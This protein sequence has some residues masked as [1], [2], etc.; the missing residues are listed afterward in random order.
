MP[1]EIHHLCSRKKE[2]KERE[3]DRQKKRQQ[4]VYTSIATDRTDVAV[5]FFLVTQ[6]KCNQQTAETK[7]EVNY[8]QIQEKDEKNS[9]RKMREKE[10]KRKTRTT[11]LLS[12]GCQ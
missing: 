4:E 5:A 9:K 6:S 11:L 1:L 2:E 7:L 3:R 10:V 8:S 12:K